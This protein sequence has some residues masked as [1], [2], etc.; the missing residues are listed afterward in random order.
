MVE[1]KF[2]FLPLWKILL[3]EGSGGGAEGEQGELD[4][5]Q[6]RRVHELS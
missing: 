3:V 4:L 1:R 5:R 2:L 6:T